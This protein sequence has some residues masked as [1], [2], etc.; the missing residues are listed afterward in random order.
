MNI[1]E[2]R[3][4]AHDAGF[5]VGTRPVFLG[6]DRLGDEP[7][8]FHAQGGK[9]FEECLTKFAEL[10]A[11]VEREACAKVCDDYARDKEEAA[12]RDHIHCTGLVGKE[13]AAT[14]LAKAIR[15]RGEA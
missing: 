5:F 6:G 11:A 13:L 3:K 12:A 14:H 7:V 4:M 9:P 15:A 1:Q 8:M 2:L 10:V